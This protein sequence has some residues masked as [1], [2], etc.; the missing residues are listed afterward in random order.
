[1]YRL[2]L[3]FWCACQIFFGTK[4]LSVKRRKS[5]NKLF[6]PAF[7]LGI[8]NE[9]LRKMLSSVNRKKCLFVYDELTLTSDMHW[10]R[11]KVRTAKQPN[12]VRLRCAHQITS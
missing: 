4:I 10:T 3:P 1:M 7:E 9:V 11:R 6:S 12:V 2:N 8:E 5:R